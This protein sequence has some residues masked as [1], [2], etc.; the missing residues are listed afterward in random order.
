MIFRISAIN[1]L[2]AWSVI[3]LYTCKMFCLWGGG[4]INLLCKCI[5]LL[6]NNVLK[7]FLKTAFVIKHR[8]KVKIEKN[9]CLLLWYTFVILQLNQGCLTL[10]L[11]YICQNLDEKNVLAILFVIHLLNLNKFKAHVWMFMKQ[12]S[13]SDK[14]EQITICQNSDNFF[15]I[16]M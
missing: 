7:I 4:Y 6:L 15:Q 8:F 14:S 16:R 11:F 1:S 2:S 10:V 5:K 12:C 9:V 3:W 13:H